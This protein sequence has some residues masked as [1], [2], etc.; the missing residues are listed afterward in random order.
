MLEESDD[1]RI[2]VGSLRPPFIIKPANPQSGFKAIK[3]MSVSE[4]EAVVAS[5]PGDYPFLVQEWV[6]GTDKDLYFCAL[7][8]DK[9]DLLQALRVTSWRPT[10]RRW[11][12]PRLRCLS[13][14][15]NYVK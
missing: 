10:R 14:C 7:Y 3:C 15:L 8:L 11:D 13:T 6:G 5:Y 1:P 9:G 2:R 12:R 4:L